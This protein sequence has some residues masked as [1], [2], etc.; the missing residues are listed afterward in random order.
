MHTDDKI[1][2]M[3]TYTDTHNAQH[4]QNTNVRLAEKDTKL[5]FIKFKY[6][7]AVFTWKYEQ[8]KIKGT[9]KRE[10][11]RHGQLFRK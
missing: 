5:N 3:K 10:I 11:Q 6:F 8:R 7:L 1:S 9:K 4:T 2:Y